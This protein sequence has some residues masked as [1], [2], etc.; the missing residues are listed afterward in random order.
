MELSDAGLKL[1]KEFEGFRATTY[2]DPAGLPTIGY[3]HKLLPGESYPEGTNESRAAELLTAD[4]VIACRAVESLVKVPLTQSQ[5]DALVDFCFN[6]GQG[7][8]AN[9]TLLRDLNAGDY[10]AARRQLLL[11]DHA[12]K[13]VVP[14]LQAR[15]QAEFD[16]WG[17][18]APGSQTAGPP[19]T[20]GTTLESQ[21]V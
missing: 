3:G 12:G 10:D 9:S 19:P 15:R 14:G 18:A 21:T 16:L 8:L 13:Q 20:A 6:L 5:F 7:R 17:A 11:W 4:A 2:L 1:I